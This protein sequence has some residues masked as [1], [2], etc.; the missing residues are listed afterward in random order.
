MRTIVFIKGLGLAVLLSAIISPASVHSSERLERLDRLEAELAAMPETS[1]FD[2]GPDEDNTN[3]TPGDPEQSVLVKNC[4][5]E[6]MF[7]SH[8]DVRS[9]RT[10]STGVD[11]NKIDSV[12][13]VDACAD[14]AARF[15]R[16]AR[17][18][19][20]LGRALSAAGDYSESLRVQRLAAEMGDLYA[21]MAIGISHEYGD[22]LPEDPSEAVKWYLKAAMQGYASAQ[23]RLGVMYKKGIGVPKDDA[24]AVKWYSRAAKQ[25]DVGAQTNL[26]WMYRHGRNLPRN[27]SEAL[28]WYRKAAA[29]GDALA[30]NTLG[31][32]YRNGEGVPK[33]NA[34]AVKW[35]S[36][37]A[38]QGYKYAQSNL[39]F[40]YSRGLSVPR[41]PKLAAELYFEA[42]SGGDDWSVKRRQD[43]WDRETALALQSLLREAGLYD[44]NIDGVIGKETKDAVRALIDRGS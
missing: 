3:A 23:N 34:E 2:N 6:A 36:M 33:D 18:L 19:A 30:Q 10:R 16:H 8:P 44:G 14:A 42:L 25:G 4:D 17:S 9:G 41:S 37:A 24:E 40:M 22:G 31:R 26:G 7:P 11:Y 43:E 39:G 28:K 32:M 21:V 38:A 27:V 1:T 5:R 12:A 20:N 35:Y 15:P 13:A 29:Q